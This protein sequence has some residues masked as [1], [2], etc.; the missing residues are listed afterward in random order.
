MGFGKAQQ[1]SGSVDS[2]GYLAVSSQ[3]IILYL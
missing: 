3:D 2:G 1:V